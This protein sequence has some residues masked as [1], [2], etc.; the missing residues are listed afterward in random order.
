[1]FLVADFR[2]RF[3]SLLAYQFREFNPTVALSILHTASCYDNRS[4]CAYDELM[5]TFTNHDLKRLDLYSRNMADHHLI[6]DLLPA[7][8]SCVGGREGCGCGEVHCV[9]VVGGV[10]EGG[11]YGVIGLRTSWLAPHFV[12]AVMRV[13]SA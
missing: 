10:P 7:C 11:S 12:D 5:M 2:G 1:M 6:T 9:G 8:M 13:Q 4:A 3:A